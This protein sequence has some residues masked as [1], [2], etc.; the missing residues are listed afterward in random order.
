MSGSSLIL[1]GGGGHCRSVIDLVKSVGEFRIHGILDRQENI[2]KSVAGCTVIGT[3]SM[4]IDLVREGH[5][6]LI[7]AGQVDR[8]PLRKELFDA[9]R[10]AGGELVTIVSPQAYVVTGVELGAGCTIGHGAVVNSGARIGDNCIVNTGAIIEHDALVGSHCHIATGA[11]VNGGCTIGTACMIGSRAVLLQGIHVGAE[12]VVGAGA[13]VL[14][15]VTPG[16]TVVG[17]PANSIT[18]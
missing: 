2:G 6:F 5:S 7:T 11:V 3:D 17:V 4:I 8:S 1:V 15:D 16:L 9:V 13:V 10:S 12:C 14:R 18:K